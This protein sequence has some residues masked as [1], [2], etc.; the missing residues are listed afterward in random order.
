MSVINLCYQASLP[1]VKTQ[2]SKSDVPV[3][4]LARIHRHHIKPL[5]LCLKDPEPRTQ[6]Q[7]GDLILTL[8]LPYICLCLSGGG[9]YDIFKAKL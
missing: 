5:S 8:P 4:H 3:V 6:S 9:K 7:I 1:I 2:D